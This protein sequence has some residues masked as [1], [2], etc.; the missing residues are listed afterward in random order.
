MRIRRKRSPNSRRCS[1]K[2]TNFYWLRM[3]TARAKPSPGTCFRSSTPR[4]RFDAWSL[5]R[6][7]PK[8]FSGRPQKP[9]RLI[10][11]LLMRK[12]RVESW[13]G[14]MG[15]KFRPCCGAKLCR[16]CR[17]VGCSRWQP[18]WLW[19]ASA[20]ALLLPRRGISTLKV[21]STQEHLPRVW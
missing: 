10:K 12:R 8:P 14:S 18:D 9:V 1:K 6:S 11:T 19:I 15:M 13:T 20:S 7:R 2:Q 16:V 5:T 4:F 21:C 17:L 3:R